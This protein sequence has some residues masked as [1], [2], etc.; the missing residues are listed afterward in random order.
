MARY[1]CP[2]SDWMIPTEFLLA[3][4]VLSGSGFK[5]VQ[6][7][8]ELRA[9]SFLKTTDAFLLYFHHPIS[10]FITVRKSSNYFPVFGRKCK[11]NLPFSS[12]IYF[13]GKKPQKLKAKTHLEYIFEDINYVQPCLLFLLFMFS[14]LLLVYYPLTSLHI[15]LCI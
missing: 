2:S 13:M 8:S 9:I 11:E 12:A 3:K 5:N 14:I 4:C 1:N 6:I 10:C 7:L 15:R